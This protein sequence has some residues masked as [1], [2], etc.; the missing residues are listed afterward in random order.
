MVFR[1]LELEAA[2]EDMLSGIGQVAR[3]SDKYFPLLIGDS[4]YFHEP[5][6]LS[7]KNIGMHYIK[8]QASKL[9]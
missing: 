8:I 1:D 2:G 9:C 7:T 4:A 5:A 6:R 3:S